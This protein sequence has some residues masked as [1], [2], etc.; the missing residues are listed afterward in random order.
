MRHAL[1]LLAVA[2]A[3]AAA[4]G[5]AAAQEGGADRAY[6]LVVGSNAPG[7]GQEPL[8]WAERD[9]E[10]MAEVLRDLAGYQ[11]ERIEVLTGPTPEA[12][13]AALDGMA[14]RLEADAAAGR[15]AVF[16]FYYSGHARSK[17][18]D[19]G[20]RQLSLEALRERVMALPTTLTIVVL[21][22]CQSGAFSRVKGAEPAADFSFNSIAGL[23]AEGV[24]VMAS[25]S[26]TELSQESERLTSSY[27]THYLLVALR[28]AGDANGDGRVSL[29]EAYRYAYTATLAT[30]ARTAVGGQHVTL[31][32]DLRGKGEV[33]LTF[34]ARADAQLELPAELAATV[35]VQI[36]DHGAV[37]AEVEKSA[38]KAL[39][40]ALPAGAYVALVRTGDT[41]VECEVGLDRGAITPLPRDRCRPVRLEDTATKGAGGYTGPRYAIELGLGFTVT[42]DSAYTETL[43]DFG[44]GD[45]TFIVPAL[46]VAGTYRMSKH[47]HLGGEIGSLELSNWTRR[48]DPLDQEFNWHVFG[49]GVFAR[50]VLPTAN[51]KHA[52]YA[53]VGGGLASGR[54]R[55]TDSLGATMPDVEHE[56]HWGYHLGAGAGAYFTPFANV[57][58]MARVRYDYAPVLDNLIGDTHDSGGLSAGWGLRVSF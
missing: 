12:L 58:L 22:A 9:A 31:E 51:E 26:G 29:D 25:S 13:L 1:T 23:R 11:A 6:A 20:P 19:L 32:T 45:Q 7:E 30:T 5:S 43:R 41:A 17:A 35:L 28:G 8:R 46:S 36:K 50:G 10:R 15:R 38:G 14:A 56:T 52:L 47:L 57:S 27:F 3:I 42:G 53:Q 54:T 33:P 16:F 37:M 44:F 18:L 39:R 2:S 24:A 4:G 49:L 40:L 21:D 55:Y 48:S 34:P